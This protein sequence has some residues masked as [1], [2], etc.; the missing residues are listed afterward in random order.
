MLLASKHP[1]SFETLELNRNERDRRHSPSATAPY[2]VRKYLLRTFA[3]C[4]TSEQI[5]ISGENNAMIEFDCSDFERRAKQLHA[6][7]DAVPYELAKAM[8]EA[9]KKTRDVLVNDTWPSHVTQR[10]IGFIGRALRRGDRATKRNLRVEIFDSLGRAHLKLH[11]TGGEKT[12]RG[13]F[14][15]PASGVIRRTSRGVPKNKRPSVII[16]NTPKRALRITDKGIFVGKGGRLQQMYAFRSSTAQ[17]AD[18]PFH[19]VFRETMTVE[20]R[21]SLPPQLSALSN[22]AAN[23]QLRPSVLRCNK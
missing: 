2:Q 14:A 19:Q 1:E 8:N 7:I 15:I 22:H 23:D 16:A 6:Q 10:N 13:K 17:P 3:R 11:D 20:L 5:E 4:R 9:V 18:V 12:A 21:V